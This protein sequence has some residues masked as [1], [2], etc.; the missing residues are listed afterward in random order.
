MPWI[1]EEDC[2]GCGTCVEAC[3]VGAISQEDQAARIDME[4]CIRCGVCHDACPEEAVRHDSE[5]IPRD[6]AA[7]VAYA[8]R[9]AEDCVRLL[10]SS[11]EGPRCLERCIKHFR[12]ALKVAEKTIKELEALQSRH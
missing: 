5:T 2:N 6:V 10:G 4:L 1:R 8:Q 7:N 11:E 9:C 12:R 3:P